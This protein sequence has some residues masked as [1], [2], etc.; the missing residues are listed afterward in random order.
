MKRVSDHAGLERL[1]F[2]FNAE[3]NR[4]GA[5]RQCNRYL[6]REEICSDSLNA[7]GSSAEAIA[8]ILSNP[9]LLDIPYFGMSDLE[10]GAL[11]S[12]GYG[13]HEPSWF[14][15]GNEAFD[16]EGLPEDDRSDLNNTSSSCE[17]STEDDGTSQRDDSMHDIQSEH[18][19]ETRRTIKKNGLK[20]LKPPVP[21]RINPNS[22][23]KC[24]TSKSNGVLRGL[25]GLIRRLV[26]STNNI[27]WIVIRKYGETD[28]LL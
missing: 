21:L 27:C 6:Q 19:N 17:E 7:C 18:L 22:L 13:S 5:R 26:I 28:A 8:T 11:T 12:C 23:V 25:S 10:T 9:G 15:L 4:C 3:G 16:D 24:L 1:T 2:S 20:I 14:S